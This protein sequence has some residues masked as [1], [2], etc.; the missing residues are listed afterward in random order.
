MTVNARRRVHPLVLALA[1]TVALGAANAH[2]APLPPETE[3]GCPY[4]FERVAILDAGFLL[5]WTLRDETLAVRLVTAGTGWVAIGWP[6]TSST[7]GH[8]DFDV[9]LGAVVGGTPSIADY[10]QDTFAGPELDIQQDVTLL[11]GFET[12]SGTTL[13]LARAFDTG[14]AAEDN[15]IVAGPL[16]LKWAYQPVSDDPA[17][18]HVGSSRGRTFVEILPPGF[19]FADGFENGSA[20]AWSLV[21]P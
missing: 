2:A 15:P 6:S 11:G 10:Y 14:D 16:N 8:T 21:A 3:G 13:E 7:T 20:C 19:A 9:S 17:E 1:A 4:A 12:V 5:Q 18:S